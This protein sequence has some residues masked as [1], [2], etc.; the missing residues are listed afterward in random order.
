MVVN[1]FLC[2]QPWLTDATAV[3]VEWDDP[4][5]AGARNPAC[6]DVTLSEGCE[7]K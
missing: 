2:S 6:S 1:L 7:D 5:V 4:E 3:V